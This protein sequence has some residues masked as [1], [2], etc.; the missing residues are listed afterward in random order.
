MQ[1]KYFLKHSNQTFT[2]MTFDT[3]TTSFL[4][5]GIFIIIAIVGLAVSFNIIKKG[6]IEPAKF[7]KILDLF[8]YTIVTVGIA[9]VTLIISDLFKEREQTVKELEYFDK[10]VQDVRKVDSIMP[11]LQVARYLSIVAPS[12]PIKKSW[13]QYYDSTKADYTALLKDKA[14]KK[15][16]D[17]VQK[18]TVEQQKEKESLTASIKLAESPLSASGNDLTAARSWE[19]QGFQYLLQKDVTNAINCFVKSENAY[20]TYHQVY[21]ISRYLLANVKEL[22]D[23]KSASWKPAY[24]RIVTDFP[25]GMPTDVMVKL[26]EQTK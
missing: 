9:T 5:Y 19:E 3:G 6:T 4:L 15:I 7:D 26:K 1:L 2:I 12:G 8:K 10:Y 20:R 21:E 25:Y 18:P 17:A 24:L 22:T 13:Q 14:A 11:R 16:L 23:P